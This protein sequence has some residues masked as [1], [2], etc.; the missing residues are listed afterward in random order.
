ML[1]RPAYRLGETITAAIEF[2]AA[3][4]PCYALHASLETSERVDGAIALRSDA[5][6]RRVT[7]KIHSSHSEATLFAR[8]IIFTPTIPSTATPS[9]ITSG[10]SLDW[11]IV[12]EFVTPRFEALG[13]DKMTYG[14]ELV[15]EISRDDRGVILAAVEGIECETFEVVV[16]LRVYGA[17]VGITEKEDEMK[18]FVV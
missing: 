16:P 9:F 6:I 1:T 17:L 15:E 12:I 14:P 2:T 5:S 4:I 3:D 11:K 13:D 7:R 8:R 18:G 10:V